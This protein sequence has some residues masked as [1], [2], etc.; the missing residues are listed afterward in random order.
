MYKRQEKRLAK[1]LA[2]CETPRSPADPALFSILFK[3]P[4]DKGLFIMAISESMA[5]L[6]CLY[7]RGLLNRSLDE[8]G[9]LKFVA[10]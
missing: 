5:H 7:R 1:L 4:I 8:E 9:K 2:A 6:N 10:S 3:R